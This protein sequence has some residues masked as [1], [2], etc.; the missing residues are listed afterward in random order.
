MQ[1]TECMVVQAS[2]LLRGEAIP[3]RVFTGS[4]GIT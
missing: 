4:Q 3:K 2:S 1:D